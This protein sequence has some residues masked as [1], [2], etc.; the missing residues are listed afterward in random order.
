MQNYENISNEKNLIS[1]K[2]DSFFKNFSIY[3]YLYT[4]N[5]KK[6]KGYNV[7]DVIIKI[8]ELPFKHKNFYQGIV[9]EKNIEFNKNVAYD[10]LNNCNYNWRKFLLNIVVIII[11]TFFKTL[12]KETREDVIIIDDTSHPRNCSKKVELLAKLHDHVTGKFLKGFRILSLCWSDGNSLLPIDFS[13][14][15]SNK[16]ENRYQEINDKIDKRSCGYQRR[17]EAISK[18]TDLILPMVKRALRYGI[19]AKYILFDSWYSFPSLIIPLKAMIDV[20]CMV[21]KMPNVY[22][23]KDNQSFTL[24]Q[25][26]KEIKKRRGKANIKGSQIVQIRNEYQELEVKI[27][28]VKNRNK[29]SDWLAILST[30]ITLS[31]EEIVRIYGKRWDIEVFFKMIKQCLNLNKEVALRN[32]DGIIAHTTIVMFRYVF[33]SVEQRNSTDGKTFGGM[34]REVIE[35]MEDITVIEALNRIL[36]LAFEKIRELDDIS[37]EKIDEILDIFMGVVMKEYGLICSAA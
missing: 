35:E 27:V 5:I 33:L 14:L 1:K 9:E 28:F 25:L 26:Y 30:D 22:Y 12:T 17:K 2:I 8:A 4:A 36:I 11:N 10:F 6:I 19:K 24:C 18:S 29:R 15:S 16:A 31:D 32:F 7:K 34:F 37:K 21:K 13:L 23:Y 20:I 3:K